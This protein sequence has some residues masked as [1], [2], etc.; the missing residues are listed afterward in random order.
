MKNKIAT[1]RQHINDNVKLIIVTKNQS[2]QD[3]HKIYS[4]GEHNF[5][6]NKVQE[7]LQKQKELPKDINWHFIG[8]LQTKKV[9]L[10]APFVHNT[11]C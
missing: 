7:L 8:H 3:V 10:I 11:I 1:I 6:E 2:T 5:G 4:L 9:K